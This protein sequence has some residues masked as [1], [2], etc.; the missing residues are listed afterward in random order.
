MK[1]PPVS[2]AD[3]KKRKEREAYN[4]LVLRKFDEME[5][6]NKRKILDLKAEVQIKAREKL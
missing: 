6:D 3:A 2:L 4:R 5:H 1:E